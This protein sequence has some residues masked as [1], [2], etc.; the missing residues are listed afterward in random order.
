MKAFDL[1]TQQHTDVVR[2]FQ[3]ARGT[4]G[5]EQVTVITQIARALYI[6]LV[7]E[8]RHL[9]P[10]FERHGLPEAAQTSLL[11]HNEV[12]L[13]LRELMDLRQ[14]DPGVL[15]V[16]DRLDLSFREHVGTEEGD[17]FPWLR[18]RVPE[19]ELE[20]IGNAMEEMTRL[21]LQDPELLERM[22][23]AEVLLKTEPERE[24]P[25]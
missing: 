14:N 24:R 20:E 10:A 3:R 7:I 19:E 17:L 23:K 2:D 21:L 25:R 12:R 13:L 8:E 15:R 22:Q 1:L 6:H 18:A 16:L 11:E 5:D 9:Y 4:S